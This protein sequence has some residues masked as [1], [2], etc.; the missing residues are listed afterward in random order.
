MIKKAVLMVLVGVLIV[1]SASISFANQVDGMV[2][3]T[4]VALPTGI[5]ASLNPGGLGDSLL[6]GYYNV[7]GAAD[8]FNVVNTSTTQ[9]VKARVVFRNAKNSVECLD[10]SICLS[11]GDVWTGVLLDN[12]TTAVLCSLDSD[13]ITDPAIP[14]NC[15]PFKYSGAGGISGVTADD[16]REGYFEIIGMTGIPGYDKNNRAAG[17]IDTSAECGSFTSTADVLNTLMGNNTIVALDLTNTMSY[18][19]TAV[20]DTAL[21]PVPLPAGS[22]LSIPNAMAAGRNLSSVVMK[23][24]IYSR[25]G[26]LNPL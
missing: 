10:F 22:E 15:Q 19:A 9:G 21:I 13:T 5:Q 20:A 16:C 24:I 11:E 23:L 4:G 6:Y 12:G 8:L 26:S 7:R 3:G 17:T 1:F 2:S 14:A 25:R 18:N